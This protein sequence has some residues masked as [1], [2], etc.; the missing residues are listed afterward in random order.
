MI[1]Y[2][3]QVTPTCIHVTVVSIQ[4]VLEVQWHTAQRG[5]MVVIESQ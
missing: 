5:I 2:S 1:S 3:S 4:V